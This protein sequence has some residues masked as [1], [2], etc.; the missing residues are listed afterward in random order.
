MCWAL[1]AGGVLYATRGAC[2]RVLA[3]GRA[4]FA[5]EES[6]RDRL[7][8]QQRAIQT[9]MKKWTLAA[10]AIIAMLACSMPAA[11][12]QLAGK[13]DPVCSALGP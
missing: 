4:S 11:L 2:A 8:Q 7:R 13:A 10:A 5:E 12:L 6:R 9:H 1:K 3:R